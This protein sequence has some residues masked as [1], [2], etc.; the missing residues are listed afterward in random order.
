MRRPDGS[1]RFAAH[2]VEGKQSSCL[3]GLLRGAEAP[4]AMTFSYVLREYSTY[5]Q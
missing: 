5:V 4:L 3:G 1:T 2:R